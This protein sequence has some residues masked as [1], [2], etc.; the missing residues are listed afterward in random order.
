MLT[1]DQA[2][3]HLRVD[4]DHDDAYIEG[5]VAAASELVRGLIARAPGPGDAAPVVPP[6]NETQRQAARLLVGHWY[7]NRE[8]AT[9][10]ALTEA[11]LAVRMLLDFNRPPESFL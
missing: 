2:K 7:A 11:P 6:V 5:L 9:P 8:A 1:L 4:G 10:V 3:L